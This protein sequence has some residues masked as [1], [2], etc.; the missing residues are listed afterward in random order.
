MRNLIFL[1]IFSGEFWK[2]Q[3][4]RVEYPPAGLCV[5]FFIIKV[6]QLLEDSE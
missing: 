5:I 1:L 2:I 4:C 6:F 3:I